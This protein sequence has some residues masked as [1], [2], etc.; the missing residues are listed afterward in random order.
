MFTRREFPVPGVTIFKEGEPVTKVMIIQ[1]G[2]CILMSKRIP[3]ELSVVCNSD[4]PAIKEA[5]SKKHRVINNKGY[6][7]KTTNSMQI[8]MVSTKQF[9]GDELMLL[10]DEPL[11]YSIIT[12]GRVVAYEISAESLKQIP[13]EIQ[14]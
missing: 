7:S 8:G 3:T 10:A 14:N 6:F 2:E 5:Q 13:K 4:Y 11:P 12:R 9:I 1:E